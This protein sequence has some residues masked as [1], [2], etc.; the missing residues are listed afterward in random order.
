LYDRITLL[1]WGKLPGVYLFFGSYLK[2]NSAFL[3][4][5]LPERKINERNPEGVAVL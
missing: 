3:S 5:N 1:G 2:I 4:E